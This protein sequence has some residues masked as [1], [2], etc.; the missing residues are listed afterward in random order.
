MESH[1]SNLSYGMHFSRIISPPINYD[2]WNFRGNQY[3][4]SRLTLVLEKY[5]R[6]S[7]H[8]WCRPDVLKPPAMLFEKMSYVSLIA[9][10]NVIWLPYL[11]TNVKFDRTIIK[12]R[13]QY[14]IC[15]LGT[16][17]KNRSTQF[18]TL[19]SDYS[20]SIK[21]R[22]ESSFPRTDSMTCLGMLTRKG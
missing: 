17:L 16:Q 12:F 20:T 8:T 10:S 22:K 19:F 4:V 2:S 5:E 18:D 9:K 7:C 6:S 11:K 21:A 13:R 15:Q 14:S 3:N 1:F